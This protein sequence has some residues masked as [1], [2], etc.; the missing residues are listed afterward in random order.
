MKESRTSSFKTS[1]AM[2]MLYQLIKAR[3][4]QSAAEAAR[5]QPEFELELHERIRALEC[6]LIQSDMDQLDV[7]APGIKVDGQ[8]YRRKGKTTKEYMTIAG[9]VRVERTVYEPRGGHGGKTISPFEM[10]LGMVNGHWTQAAANV[11]SL[12]MSSLPSKE[13]AKLL[14]KSGNMQPSA[15]H[16][17]RLPKYI[18]AIWEENREKLEAAIREAETL[19]ASED[20]AL[21][22][23][24]LDGVMVP[25]KDAPRESGLKKED[26]G[27]KGHKEASCA[28]ISLYNQ[29]GERLHTIKFG[30]MPESK[31][32]TLQKQLTEEL[33]RVVKLYPEVPVEA[34]ADGAEE[35]WRIVDEV[36]TDVGVKVERV[37]DYYHAKEYLATAMREYAGSNKLNA[38]F[39]IYYW[40][41]ELAEEP[42][43]VKR[44][45]NALKYRLKRSRG[46]KH[47]EIAKALNYIQGHKEMMNYCALRKK[48][49][50]IGSGVQEAACKTLVSQRMK[51]SGMSWRDS[52]G[53]AILTL[54]GLDQ[55]NRWVHAWKAL[56]PYLLQN[57]EIDND[58]SRQRP[59]RP[60]PLLKQA[61]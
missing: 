35:N 43:G 27:S 9:K 7:S 21:I 28:T 39:D 33:R 11:A 4:E 6:E 30:R 50:P 15:S 16:L 48:N 56:K 54:R 23:F 37:L 36:A 45:I 25:M 47:E 42:K 19:P 12:Y 29:E 60:K 1:S 52:G 59:T 49:W 55:S 18:N 41:H 10:R 14:A 3:D 38:K 24:S 26:T 51:H 53:Q 40:S 58:L 2:A 22:M 46:K 34:C 8:R 57:Y 17:D 32:V 61:A 13:A 20:V 5:T 31:K 44:L